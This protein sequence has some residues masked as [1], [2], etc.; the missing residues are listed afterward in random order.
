[1]HFLHCFLLDTHY[2]ENTI[3]LR[4]GKLAAFILYSYSTRELTA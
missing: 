4:G 3:R 2:E 1:M